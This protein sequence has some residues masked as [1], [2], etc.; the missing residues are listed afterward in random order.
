MGLTTHHDSDEHVE[1]DER[2]HDHHGLEEQEGHGIFA[3]AIRVAAPKDSN[4]HYREDGLGWG[5]ECF[6]LEEIHPEGETICGN[7]DADT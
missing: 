1:Q 3:E 7:R 6:L 4:I 5:R 2:D